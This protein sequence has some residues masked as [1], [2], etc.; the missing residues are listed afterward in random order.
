MKRGLLI[1]SGVVVLALVGGVFYALSSLEP[2]I[3]EAVETYGSDV[4]RAEVT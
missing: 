2:L 4:T 3:K 1:G